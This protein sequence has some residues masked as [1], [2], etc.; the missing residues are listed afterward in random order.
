VRNFRETAS[1]AKRKPPGREPSLRT[2]ENVEQ[3]RQAFARSP[4]RSVSRNAIALR[5]SDRTVHRILHKD[6]N[7]HPYKMVMVQ[8]INNQDIVNRKT[9]CDVLDND[10]LNHVLMTDEANFHL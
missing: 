3:V 10:D 2:H 9:V 1:A 8:A 6:L 4:R 7:F 5:I